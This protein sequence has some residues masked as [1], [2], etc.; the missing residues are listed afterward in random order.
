MLEIKN[1]TLKNKKA[2]FDYLFNECNCFSFVINRNIK[3]NEEIIEKNFS[4]KILKKIIYSHANHDKLYKAVLQK[5][6]SNNPDY[7]SI[8]HEINS[9]KESNNYEV[10][11]LENKEIKYFCKLDESTKNIFQFYKNYIKIKKFNYMEDIC[12][13]KEKTLFLETITHENLSFIFCKDKDEEKQLENIGISGV[14]NSYEYSEELENIKYN[15][16]SFIEEDIFLRF[17]NFFV[18]KEIQKDFLSNDIISIYY[19]ENIKKLELYLN[20]KRINFTVNEDLIVIAFLFK[21][22]R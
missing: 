6:D 18:E 1:L 11:I 4:G 15:K 14:F 5:Y 19:Y 10:K 2:I 20:N 9:I 21:H 8:Y 16:N 13:Y 3:K 17:K 12:F 7:E 22:K